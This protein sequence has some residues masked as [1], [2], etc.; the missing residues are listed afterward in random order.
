MVK[1]RPYIIL[2]A[3]VSLDGKIST[4]CGDSNIS[5]VDDK[6]RLHKLRNT[7][8]GILIGINTVKQDNPLLTIRYIQYSKHPVRIILDSR[9][10]ISSNTKI[11]K[12]SDKFKT[13]IVVSEKISKN[14]IN[15]LKCAPV[16]MIICGKNKIDIKNLLV[17]LVKKYS[18]S[19]ILVEG[20]SHI[21][22]SF[23]SENIF[24][25]LIV[26]I[27]PYLVGGTNST[28][29]LSGSGLCNIKDSPKL[30]LKNVTRINN[31]LVLNYLN[32]DRL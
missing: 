15:R 31:E 27:A 11:I 16:D 20:G 24:D 10:L 26:T 22:W 12:T 30:K 21:N 23:I 7:V 18:M 8:D 2:S 3:A 17:H 32:Q 14:N 9:G 28:S 5:S 25:E 29:F 6:I 1:S 19:R 13:I 4:K